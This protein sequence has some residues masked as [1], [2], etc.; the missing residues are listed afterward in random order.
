MAKPDTVLKSSGIQA[1]AELRGLKD[2]DKFMAALRFF[3]TSK[4]MD[5]SAPDALKAAKHWV[6]YCTTECLTADVS[7]ERRFPLVICS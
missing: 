3:D 2:G 6:R 5:R 4:E 7:S 1:F